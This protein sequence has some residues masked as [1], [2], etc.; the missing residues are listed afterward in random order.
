MSAGSGEPIHPSPCGTWSENVILRRWIW[1]GG[2]ACAA[3]VIMACGSGGGSP[4]RPSPTSL[5]T[6]GILAGSLPERGTAITIPGLPAVPVGLKALAP[7]AQAPATD[8]ILRDRT[9][10]LV[11]S[12]PTST[13]RPEVSLQVTFELWSISG[14]SAALVHT[15][16]VPAG[17]GTTSVMV[18]PDTLVD[19]QEYAWRANASLDGQPGPPS[20]PWAFQTE[21]IVISPPT[22]VSPIGGETTTNHQPSLL[23]DNGAVQGEAGTVVYQFEL[24][25]DSSFSDPLRLESV[26]EGNTGDRTTRTLPEALAPLTTFYWRVRGTNHTVDSEWSVTEMFMTPDESLDEIN[27]SQITWLHA[28]ISGWTA[29]ST[30]TGITFPGAGAEMC[31]FHTQAGEWPVYSDQGNL[32][33]GNPWV[34]AN[35]NGQWVGGTF[36]WLRPGQQCKPV[37]TRENIGPHVKL[38]PLSTWVPQSGELVGFA[39]STPARDSRRTSNQRSNIVLAT[40]P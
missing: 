4:T 39:M 40:W 20:I 37:I 38:L 14:T 6:A 1:C 25:T 12:T 18:P 9:L 24:D 21:F 31:I 15:T 13:Y 10:Q 7:V 5:T 17:S 11:V 16:T 28:D 22:L 33:E 8:T 36:E 3:L 30:V 23:V 2:S 29:S 34:F 35:I 27:P 19:R 32:G 26:R